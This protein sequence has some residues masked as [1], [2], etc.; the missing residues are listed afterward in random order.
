MIKIIGI[1]AL[2][3]VVFIS[4]LAGLIA[5]TGNLNKEG[6]ERLVKKEET[7]S[8]EEADPIGLSLFHH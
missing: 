3:F 6:L 8:G 2:A 7:P 1:L 5:S 4:T